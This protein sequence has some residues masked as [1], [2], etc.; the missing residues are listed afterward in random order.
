MF[1]VAHIFGGSIDREQDLVAGAGAA[2]DDHW[3]GHSAAD[4]AGIWTLIWSS[5]S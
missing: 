2:G 3:N 4:A 5:P 1:L